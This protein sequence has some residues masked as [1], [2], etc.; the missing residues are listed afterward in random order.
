MM[1]LKKIWEAHLS[2]VLLLWIIVTA[3]IRPGWGVFGAGILIW[4]A[5]LYLTAP[6]V[7]WN[8]IALITPHSATVDRLLAKS[9]SYKPLIPSPYLFLGLS[10]ARGKKWDQAIPLLEKAVEYAPKH[11]KSRNMLRLGE[12]YHANSL[13]EKALATFEELLKNG[14]HSTVLFQN[15]AF[16]NLQLN[17]LPEALE[18]A[19]KARAGNLSD[20]NPVLI[21]AKIHF[22]MGDYQQAKDDYLWVIDHL[23]W[24]VESF[25]WLGRAE[26][27][28][29]ET[30]SAVNHLQTAVERITADPLLSDVSKE[31]AEEWLDRALESR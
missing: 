6:G 10:Y 28:L 8:Y 16:T 26:L 14:F 20:I 31:E 2:L 17:R 7:F 12:V 22:T 24:P 18:Y 29:G 30:E 1:N 9:V 27:E 23:K 13:H 4:I 3:A 25:Y 21:Q 5:L 11:Q 19:K 15:L